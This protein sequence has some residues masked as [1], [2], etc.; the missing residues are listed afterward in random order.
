M[1]NWEEKLLMNKAKG[2]KVKMFINFSNHPSALWSEEQLIA[3][4]QCG[5]I[6]DQEF[7]AVDTGLTSEEIVEMA[8]EQIKV[9]ERLV[10]AHKLTMN[11]ITIMC[12]GEFSLTYAIVTRIKGKYPRC[13]VV[14]AV[15]ER[16]T[17][18]EQFEHYTEK[19]VIFSFGGFREY[20]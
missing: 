11:E 20:L 1:W 18:E 15:S 17:V 10:A 4:K 9:I 13:K 16:Q 14:C 7:P 5:K 2:S 19:R 3:A 6:V 8:V 12:Q